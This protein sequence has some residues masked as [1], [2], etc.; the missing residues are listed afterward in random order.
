MD[1]NEQRWLGIGGLIFVVLAI[2]LIVVTPKSPALHASPATLLAHYKKSKQG[3]Y[4]L[5][6]FVTMAAVIEGLFW[7]WYFR[8]LLAAITGARRLAS[9]AF[10]GAVLLAAG[11]GL[12]AGLDFLLSDAVGHAS[13]STLEVLNYMQSNLNLGLTAA[14]VVV[15][16]AATAL[17]VIRFRA[18]PVWLGWLAV[19]FAV[20]T[21]AIT[22][23]AL[24]CIGIWM[25]PV[26]VVLLAGARSEPDRVVPRA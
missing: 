10:A 9:V 22:P 7:F 24:L 6:G 21:F 11:G 8:D 4:L 5:G 20:V 12:G 25:I 2:V 18:L 23:F 1:R 14:G 3:L 26:N 15:F 17:A 16:L 13:A 19:V